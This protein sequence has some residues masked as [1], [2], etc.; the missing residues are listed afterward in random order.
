MDELVNKILS[1]ERD[2][3]GIQLPDGSD[4][5]G[6]EG[7]SE[8]QEYLKKQELHFNPV[9]LNGSELGHLK[10]NGLYLPCVRGWRA[11]LVGAHLMEANLGEAN[12]VGADL[13]EA[14]LGG[15]YLGGVRRL[16][17]ARNLGDANPYR[18]IVTEEEEA[19]IGRTLGHKK[20]FDVRK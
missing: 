1:G 11:N 5:S 12:L 4:L 20:L 10:A 19:I 9:M 15:A 6:Y 16:E 17:F 18:T 14:N 7:F 13:R 8:M 3:S 2:F